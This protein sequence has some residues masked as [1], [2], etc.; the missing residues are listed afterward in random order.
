MRELGQFNVRFQRLMLLRQLRA[1]ARKEAGGKQLASSKKN[2]NVLEAEFGLGDWVL[3]SRATRGETKLSHN[4]T[5]PFQ[6]VDTLNPW[7]Y[8][9]RSMLTERKLI[10]TCAASLSM[11][12]DSCWPRRRFATTSSAPLKVSRNEDRG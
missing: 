6:V 2:A 12:T 8:T 4:W 11:R 10:S 3:I 9:V 5:G 7:V 1:Q